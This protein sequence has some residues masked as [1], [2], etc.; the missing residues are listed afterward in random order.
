MYKLLAVALAALLQAPAWAQTASPALT[1]PTE[2]GTTTMAAGQYQVT[3]KTNGKVY[4]LMVTGKGNM[5]L[6]PSAAAAASSG[7]A[8]AAVTPPAAVSPSAAVSPPAIAPVAGASAVSGTAAGATQGA[9]STI[10]N[11]VNQGMQRGMNELM[12]RGATNQLKNLVK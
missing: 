9:S 6:S 5:I 4:D 3:D 12:K 7:T 1:G 2:V 10:N 11:L 8:A